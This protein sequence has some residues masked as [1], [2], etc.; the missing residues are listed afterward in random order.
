MDNWTIIT[1]REQTGNPGADA[2][3]QVLA[4][5]KDAEQTEIAICGY[6]LDED[7]NE[8]DE[9]IE[10]PSYEPVRLT[11]ADRN[12]IAAALAALEWPAADLDLCLQAIAKG[13]ET[14]SA[15]A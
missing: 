4:F 14:G 10:D 3:W 5:K 6:A 9:L 12:G 11:T 1:S 8:S 2:W 13:A 7:D 15:K